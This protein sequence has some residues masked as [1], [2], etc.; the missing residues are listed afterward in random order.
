M[1]SAV[2][3]HLDNIVRPAL[4]EYVAAERALDTANRSNDQRLIDKVRQDVMRRA[5]TASIEL[6]H[7]QDVVVANDPA[8][9]ALEDIRT[10]LR[11]AC[12]FAR[13]SAVVNDTDLLRD[14]ADAFKYY[15]MDRRSSTVAGADAVVSVSN[16]YGEMRFGEQK[17]GGLEQVTVT[18]KNG[19][20]YSL[21]W[22]VQNSY[23]AWMKLLS[24][25]LTPFGDY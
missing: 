15:E 19:H 9:P 17:W 22:I 14:T 21:L 4:R 11:G 25:P 23:D 2:Q 5:R 8:Y 18:Q 20:K 13:G 16:G 10:A 6:H 7:L 1:H 3:A 24:Q 12:V